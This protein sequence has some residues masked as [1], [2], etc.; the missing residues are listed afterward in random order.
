MDVELVSASEAE[1]HV[2]K[3]DGALFVMPF[4]D[5]P[6]ARR[7]AALMAQRAAGKG[8]VL[9]VHDDAREGF[10]RIANSVFSNSE[11]A[12]FGYAAQDAYAGR[13]WLARA[14]RPFRDRSIN[15]LA[16]NDGKWFGALAAY[17]LARRSWAEGT[18][19][20]DLFFPRYR[21]HYADTELTLIALEQK[22]LGYAADSVLV[23]V[24]WEKDSR[25]VERSDRELFRERARGGFEGRVK[26]KEL[27]SRFS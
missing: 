19:G 26:S 22:A 27:Q 6:R 23:E 24:D 15:L 7:A 10:I 3:C 16:F 25:E 12:F 9:A 14:L 18:Y 8:L 17:G 2:W 11:S 5:P 21:R 20:G 4:T 13:D 1:S